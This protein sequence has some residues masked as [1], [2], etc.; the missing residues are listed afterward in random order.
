MLEGLGRGG[1]APS[2]RQNQTCMVETAQR[3]GRHRRC[4]HSQTIRLVPTHKKQAAKSPTRPQ[5]GGGLG[6]SPRG[7]ARARLTRCAQVLARLM[8][9]GPSCV[10]WAAARRE[11]SVAVFLAKNEMLPCTGAWQEQEGRQELQ[12]DLHTQYQLCEH[13]YI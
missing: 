7:A 10:E 11:G 12:G 9:V 3:A 8:A 13:S 5:L 4:Q 1:S 2:A 6:R